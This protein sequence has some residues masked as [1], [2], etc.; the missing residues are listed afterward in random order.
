MINEQYPGKAVSV[1]QYR[2]M[3]QKDL[4]R[5]M[6]GAQN[7][8]QGLAFEDL[9]SRGCEHYVYRG[10]AFVEKT[11]EPMKVLGTLGRNLFKAVFEKKAQGDYKGTLAG[12]RAVAFEAK[13]SGGDRIVKAAVSTAQSGWLDKHQGLGAVCFV[14]VAMQGRYY[15]RVPWNIWKAMQTEC[16]RQY[17]TFS[18]LKPYQIPLDL[19]MGEGR[20]NAP[21]IL[22]LHNLEWYRCKERERK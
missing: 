13:S 12:G 4:R 19:C 10:I 2:S 11:P 15:Y 8:A 20:G 6:Q 17:M 18:D 7:R 16:G 14:L 5:Q 22:F 1:E 21:G 9:I 3:A